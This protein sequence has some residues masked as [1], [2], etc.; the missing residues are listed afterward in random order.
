MQKP[1]DIKELLPKLKE[2]GLEG[3]EEAVKLAVPQI[4]DWL[5]ESAALSENKYDD[6]CSNN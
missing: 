2:A 5:I 1:Y 6:L 3:T 4:F